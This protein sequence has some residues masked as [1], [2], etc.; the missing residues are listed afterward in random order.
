MLEE[1]L[2]LE[3]ISKITGLSKEE[4]TALNK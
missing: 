4:I 3:I 2:P 1:N